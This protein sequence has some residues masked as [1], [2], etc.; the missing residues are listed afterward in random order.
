[1]L[2]RGVGSKQTMDR[3]VEA[4]EALLRFVLDQQLIDVRRGTP[5]SPRIEVERLDKAER[6]DLKQAFDA[7]AEIVDLVGEGRM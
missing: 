6:K 3:I 5:L 4:H 1:M 2:A 7:V